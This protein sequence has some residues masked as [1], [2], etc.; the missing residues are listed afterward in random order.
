[1]ATRNSNNPSGSLGIISFGE[2]R[3]SSRALVPSTRPSHALSNEEKQIAAFFAKQTFTIHEEEKKAKEAAAAIQDIR[4]DISYGFQDTVASIA[5]KQR[6]I[7]GAD[8]EAC[9]VSFNRGN[10]DGLA[11]NLL[12][13]AAVSSENIGS[14]VYT[15]PEDPPPPRRWWQR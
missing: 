6:E 2:S 15:T 1:M 12:G 10:V 9:I 8:F 7:R 4:A 5:K 13:V 3:R 14:L 11:K